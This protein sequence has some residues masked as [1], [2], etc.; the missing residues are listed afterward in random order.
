M[1]A[2]RNAVLA[3]L[4]ERQLFPRLLAQKYPH[5]LASILEAWDTPEAIENCFQELML[6]DP[7]RKQGFPESVMAEIFAIAKFHDA[8]YPKPSTSPFDIWSRAQERS[9][10][11]PGQTDE[12]V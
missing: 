3:L 7:R 6:A 8:V 10:A 5:V 4:E 1:E 11:A 9:R 12:A 2:T